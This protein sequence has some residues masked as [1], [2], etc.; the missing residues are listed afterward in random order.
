[1]ALLWG[2]H[3]AYNGCT[4]EL[5]NACGGVFCHFHDL[6][7]GAKCWMHSFTSIKKSGTQACSEHQGE[8]K[9][10]SYHRGKQSLAGVK[11]MLQQP[12]KNMPWQPSTERPVQPH[13]QPT[14]ETQ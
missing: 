8:W 14:S 1:M 12:A 2:Q 11:R 4:S 13:D 3:T 5:A 10:D 9:K 6:Q 7:Y